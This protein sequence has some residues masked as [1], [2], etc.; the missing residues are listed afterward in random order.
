MSSRK[1]K[2]DDDLDYSHESMSSSPSPSPAIHNRPL[3]QTPNRHLKRPRTNTCG[4]PLALPRLLETLHADEMRG[5]L[6]TLCDRHPDIANEI[7]TTAPRPSVSSALSVLSSY[8]S[9][10]RESFPYGDRPSSEYAFNRVRL[11]LMNL[12]DALRDY[13]PYFLPPNETQPAT[14]LAFLDGA[15]ELIHALPNWDSYQ[16]DRHKHEAYEEIAAAW[17]LVLR[18]AAKKGAGIQVQYGGWDQKI[19]KHNEIS[20]GKMQ[21]AVNELASIVGW[22]GGAGGGQAGGGG[23]GGGSADPRSIRQQL[24]AGTYGVNHPIQVGPW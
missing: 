10:L 24:M 5:L 7:V 13:T 19:A 6:R 8:Q 1:R 18:E 3:P 23:E 20:G 4:R 11:S 12:L 16:H 21:E 14:S 17:A 2:A 9:S 15:T 22:I